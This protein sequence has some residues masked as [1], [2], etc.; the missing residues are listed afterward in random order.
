[1]E[2]TLDPNQVNEKQ[3]HESDTNSQSF[4]DDKSGI[5]LMDKDLDK[6]LDKELEKDSHESMLASSDKPS[7]SSDKDEELS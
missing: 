6:E 2:T 1:M 4:V 7:S 5:L 3:Q